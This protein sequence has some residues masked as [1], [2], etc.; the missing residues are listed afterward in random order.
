MYIIFIVLFYFTK[1]AICVKIVKLLLH[2]K[3]MI[4]M[5][6]ILQKDLVVVVIGI[7]NRVIFSWFFI[8]IGKMFTFT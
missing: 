2:M 7:N 5:L 8:L 1:N 6:R 3:Q 4:E